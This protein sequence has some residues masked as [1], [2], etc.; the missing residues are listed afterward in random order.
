MS[1]KFCDREPCEEL[2]RAL[3]RFLPRDWRSKSKGESLKFQMVDQLSGRPITVYLVY[4][5]FCGTRLFENED[6]MESVEMS[7]GLNAMNKLMRIP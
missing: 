1:Y 4:C 3:P 7:A 5:P 6:I 2:K